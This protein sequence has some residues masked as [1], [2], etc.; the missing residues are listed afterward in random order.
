MGLVRP[1]TAPRYLFAGY[2][3]ER[4]SFGS[5][6]AFPAARVRIPWMSRW[7]KGGAPAWKKLRTTSSLAH[8]EITAVD[9]RSRS[10]VSGVSQPKSKEI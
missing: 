9:L 5:G 2:P 3:R 4:I 8:S 1:R 10:R 6:D 7:E